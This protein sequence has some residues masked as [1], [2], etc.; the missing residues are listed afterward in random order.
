MPD[1]QELQAMML[2]TGVSVAVKSNMA[3]GTSEGHLNP[4]MLQNVNLLFRLLI[5]TC[6]THTSQFE[7]LVVILNNGM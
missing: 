1:D 4:A 7:Q 2:Q 3:R 6:T 5:F